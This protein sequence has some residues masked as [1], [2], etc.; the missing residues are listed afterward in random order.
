MCK[1]IFNYAYMVLN[2]YRAYTV[3]LFYLKLIY[4]CNDCLGNGRLNKPSVSVAVVFRNGGS[5][6]EFVS[7]T[8]HGRCDIH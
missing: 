4:T 2:V 7:Y 3:L 8:I 1:T 5:L 6:A